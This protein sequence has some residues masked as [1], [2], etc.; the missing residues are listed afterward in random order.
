MSP[1][2]AASRSAWPVGT[3]RYTAKLNRRFTHEREDAWSRAEAREVKDGFRVLKRAGKLGAVV[4]QFPWSFR[5]Q[6][7]NREW[8][9]DLVDEFEEFPLVVE[10]RHASWNEADF[11][12]RLAGRGV[13]FVNIDQPL[14]R[15]SIRPSARATA[16][17]GYI[18]VHG[19]NYMDWFRKGAGRD[20]RYDYL[21]T[22]AELRPWAERA[23]AVAKDPTTEQV[24]VVFNNHY[25]A[26]AVVNALQFQKLL[27]GRPVPAPPALMRAYP[28]ALERHA[29]AVPPAIPGAAAA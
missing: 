14:F 7:A 16:R 27:A 1:R 20:A 23:R 17:V 26:Q 22:P 19:R 25:R 15:R 18:R 28:E 8:L 21:Y 24:D 11:Y 6:D 5:N 10:V 29:R 3:T 12:A 4:V 9:T 2:S 13:G